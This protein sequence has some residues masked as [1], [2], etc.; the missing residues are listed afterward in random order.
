[1]CVIDKSVLDLAREMAAKHPD[2]IAVAAEE[3]EKKLRRREDF[4]ELQ[5]QLLRIAYGE[6]IYDAR[7]KMN[8]EAWRHV[9]DP[10]EAEEKPKGKR[11]AM[12]QHDA[13][14]KVVLMKS[15]SYLHVYDPLYGYCIAGR[16]LGSIKGAELADIARSERSQADGRLRNARLVELLD[17]NVPH[18]K[19]VRQAVAGEKLFAMFR[20]AQIEV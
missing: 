18:D 20:Q 8:D 7:K 2:A 6:L 17:G 3:L 10:E 5:P 14:P 13:R 11:K 15:K 12:A 1:M 19:T 4:D 9:A 16:A